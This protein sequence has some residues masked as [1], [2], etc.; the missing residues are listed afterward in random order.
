MCSTHLLQKQLYIYVYT[1]ESYEYNIYIHVYIYMHRNIEG[2]C[3]FSVVKLTWHFAEVWSITPN[4]TF[5]IFFWTSFFRNSA[6]FFNTG[7]WHDCN[8]FPLF[9]HQKSAKRS[10]GR[11]DMDTGVPLSITELLHPDYVYI[12]NRFHTAAVWGY[13][14]YLNRTR[15]I[16][17]FFDQDLGL[18]ENH[19]HALSCFFLWRS[20]AWSTWRRWSSEYSAEE[21]YSLW[22]QQKK[23]PELSMFL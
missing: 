9:L 14:F 16:F 4:F 8:F 19:P 12:Y 3:S 18:Y 15:C 7:P 1:Y 21:I 22:K 5:H 10:C 2:C 20:R 6:S 17:F 11:K 23:T 13:R